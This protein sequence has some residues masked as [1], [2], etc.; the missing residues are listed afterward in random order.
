MTMARNR[1]D[2]GTRT[3]TRREVL[4]LGAATVA[5]AAAA[6]LALS[7]AMA[8]AVAWQRYKGT[9]LFLLFYKHPW[10][11]QIVKYF[12]EFEAMTGMKVQYEIIPE[13]QGREKLVI[14]MTAGS[15]GI[16][17]WHASMHVEKRRFWKSGW[18]QPL[19]AYLNDKTLTA[20]DYAW[21]DVT[22]GAKAAV[23]QPD[24]TISALPTFVDPFVLFYRKDLF[25]QRGWAP[26]KTMEE[27]ESYAKQLHSPPGMYGFVMRGLKNAN[28]T[29]WAFVL[30]AMGG[31]YLTPDRKSAMN[32]PEWVK[33]MDWYAGML[34][35]YAPPGVVNF[36]WYEC[37]AAFMQG[38]VGMYIDGV[39][40]ANQFED[41]T[42]SKI[43]GK[44]GY[45]VLPAG[46][47]GHFAPTFTNAMALS[48]Q[49]RHKE[50][51]YLLC[52][53]ATSKQNCNRE[54]LGG[55]GVGR[56]STWGLPEVK[57]RPKMPLEWY[58]AYQESVKIG[59]AGL[60]EIVDVTQYR[61]IIGVAIQKAI[62]GA[63]SDAVIAEAHKQFQELL[64][65]TET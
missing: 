25:E 44:V 7:P 1:W 45:T 57:A 24:K 42:R 51:A 30:Y 47:A 33:S 27:L 15:G 21:N 23:T 6:P 37:S 53:W 14:E 13:V 60:P 46:P 3:M 43:V 50:A 59:R 11:D 8:D 17:A 38:Q 48:A 54:L 20:E 52:E 29:P 2:A 31:R 16:D 58:S 40:F 32:S 4:A 56:A 64:D 19:N 9:Q 41:P 61:D 5:G 36:N 62:E 28:A 10:V 26:P 39:N 34:R 65:K 12:P 35:R 63:R 49:S 22:A 55:V 18:F